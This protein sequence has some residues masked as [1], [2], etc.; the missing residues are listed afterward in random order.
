MEAIKE[1]GYQGSS[2]EREK[3]KE[4]D[5]LQGEI[6]CVR[7][8]VQ[9]SFLIDVYKVFRFGINILQVICSFKIVH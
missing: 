6:F 1:N 3:A 8:A 4:V 5:A 9:L 2:R 7:F